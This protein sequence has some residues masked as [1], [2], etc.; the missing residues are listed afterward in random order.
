M[1]KKAVQ[2]PEGY[3]MDA[4]GRLVP[5]S[6]VKPIDLTRDELVA[7]LIAEAKQHSAEIARFKADTF[8]RIA[9][10]VEQSAREYRTRLGG[11]KGNVTLVSFDGRYKIVRQV[12]ETI[13]FDERLQVAKH[14]IDE[15]IERWSEGSR[16]EIRVLVN[17][18]FQVN[19]EGGLN[20]GRVLGLKKLNIKDPQWTKAMKA[21]ADSVRTSA[22][23][24][25]VRFYERA[26][27]SDQYKPISLD[28]ASA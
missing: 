9:A 25:Y 3:R 8:D 28:A 5:E 1:S 23:K 26:E 2:I 27:G 20:V 24:T 18:A 22:S 10:F 4:D 7:G 17:D 21:I 13:H 14:L 19:K 12:S 15:C 16:D 11:K 6:M